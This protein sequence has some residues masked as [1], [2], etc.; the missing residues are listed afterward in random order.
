MTARM[1]SILALIY[2]LMF[3]A[4]LL[5]PAKST[6]ASSAEKL[7][8]REIEL[9]WE[10]VEGAKSYE[11]EIKSLRAGGAT[12]NFN[13]EKATWEGDMVPGRYQMRVRAKDRRGV[14]TPWS[15]SSEFMVMLP[16]PE[17]IAPKADEEVK[18]SASGESEEIA[19]SWKPVLGATSYTVHVQSADGQ[20]KKDDKT[21]DL[22]SEI[23]LPVAQAFRWWVESSREGLTSEDL[24]GGENEAGS[25]PAASA[26]K[27][28]LLGHELPTP[29]IDDLDNDFVRRISWQKSDKAAQYSWE[30]QYFDPKTNNWVTK[31]KTEDAKEPAIGFP[32][33]WPGGR[34]R[35][36]VQ[37]KAPM[38][39]PSSVSTT[40][41]NVR[42]G[43]R[44]PEAEEVHTVR[45]SING[46]GLFVIT[47]Y[48]ATSMHYQSQNFDHTNSSV[49]FSSLGASARVGVG[50]VKPEKTWGY[51]GLL[52][53]SAFQLEGGGGATYFAGEFDMQHRR[54][55]FER[56]D[57]RQLF[58]VQFRQT[59]DV[60][61]P[62]AT[63][64][65]STE[66]V[67]S[68]NLHYGVEYWYAVN[69]KTGAQANLHLYP[70]V[71]GIS[72]PSGALVPTIS[73]QVG[74]LASRRLTKSLTALL[75]YAYRDD[76]IHY[77]ASG[78]NATATGSDVN[79]IDMKGHNV[80]LILEW[81]L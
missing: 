73:Y 32:K 26:Q 14:A 39:A 30:L 3:V 19:F 8:K 70:S 11:L 24:K 34:Y 75:G 15:E 12:K 74:L 77:R 64:K 44:S 20:I 71:F 60:S 23:K 58:G 53:A 22:K 50:Y 29:K 6:F 40:E 7:A 4:I 51:F 13:V 1:R 54:Q 48:S 43:D 57:V 18:A 80:N 27:F 36:I 66:M 47:D 5:V 68:I 59:P 67:N 72:T 41:F 56:D 79:S 21:K 16:E 49:Q 33:K 38:R 10:D 35:M 61:A 42:D 17:L 2:S 65:A 63:A 76:T 25:E 28:T 55:Y 45:E 62:I 78:N 9:N 37:A 69:A 31:H 81:A 52:D 46:R